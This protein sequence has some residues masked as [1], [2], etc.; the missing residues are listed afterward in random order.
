MEKMEKRLNLWIHEKTTDKKG[1]V[2][3]T[4]VKLKANEIYSHVTQGQKNVKPS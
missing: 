1:V 4:A 2:D 3:S